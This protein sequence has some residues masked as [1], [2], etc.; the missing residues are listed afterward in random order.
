MEIA[1]YNEFDSFGISEIVN[2]DDL[3]Q[4]IKQIEALKIALESCNTFRENAIRFAKLEASAL[5]RVCELG[6]SSKL[7]GFKKKVAEWLFSLDVAD[8]DKFIAKCSEGL[9]IDQVWKQE[10]YDD[11]KLS[12][13]LEHVYFLRDCY[14]D[15]V[16]EKGIVNTLDFADRARAELP[17]RMANDVIDGLRKKLRQIGAVGVGNNTG[18]YVMPESGNNDA[19]KKAILQRF[20]SA[21]ADFENIAEIVKAAKTT[22]AYEDFGV[23]VY[24]ADRSGHS[25]LC[26]FLLALEGMGVISNSDKMWD[27]LAASQVYSD[28]DYVVKKG[29]A[30]GVDAAKKILASYENKSAS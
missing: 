5:L 28:I 14:A 10:V 7:K 22:I 26:H 23:D 21:A 24:N 27:D 20:E 17:E 15:D 2:L 29:Y 19:V 6:G 1:V 13:K 11:Q 12:Q 25:Y 18:I 30:H 9:T 8:R 3:L 4:K 16:K